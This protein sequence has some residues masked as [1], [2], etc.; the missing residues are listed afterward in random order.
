MLDMV[1]NLENPEVHC[2][3]L[4]YEVDSPLMYAT[5]FGQTE[6]ARVLI[7]AGADATGPAGEGALIDVI[8]FRDREMEQLLLDVGADGNAELVLN[9]R[10][11]QE[12]GRKLGYVRD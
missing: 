12:A 3:P 11:F 2:N 8:K 4:T 5:T 6:A 7:E 10:A 9:E 1:R